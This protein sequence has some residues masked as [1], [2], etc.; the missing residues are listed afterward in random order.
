MLDGACQAH[1]HESSSWR[2]DAAWW[3]R[4][5]V[6]AQLTMQRSAQNR[7]LQMFTHQITS[8]EQQTIHPFHMMKG[9]GEQLAGT[10]I[11]KYAEST[12]PHM[13]REMLM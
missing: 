4:K 9:A 10:G 5:W 3:E 6:R 7:L 11:I 2:W 12:L 8:A 13:W 1:E